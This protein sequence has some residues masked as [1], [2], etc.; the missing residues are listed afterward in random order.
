MIRF[1]LNSV[2]NVRSEDW[3]GPLHYKE[4]DGRNWKRKME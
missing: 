3:E 4:V 1:L 2:E